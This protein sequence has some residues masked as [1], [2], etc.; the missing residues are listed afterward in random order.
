MDKGER[1][2]HSGAD[3]TKSSNRPEINGPCV[4]SFNRAFNS[5]T[6]NLYCLRMKIPLVRGISGI[7]SRLSHSGW[8]IHLWVLISGKFSFADFFF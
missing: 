4:G 3:M 8:K 5:R 1:G 2:E 7:G 6:K